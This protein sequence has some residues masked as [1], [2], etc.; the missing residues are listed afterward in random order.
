M[1]L[2]NRFDPPP[3]PPPL[4]PPLDNA[5]PIGE[6]GHP[7]LTPGGSLGEGL[8]GYSGSSFYSTPA[9]TPVTPALN[10]MTPVKAV[11]YVS[12]IKR[13]A[14]VIGITLG[15]AAGAFVGLGIAN[16]IGNWQPP[17]V[18]AGGGCIP[19]PP[20][21]SA[22][23]PTSAPVVANYWLH[24]SCG[25]SYKMWDN[26]YQCQQ[27]I[28]YGYGVYPAYSSPMTLADCQAIVRRGYGMTAWDGT[29]GNWCAPTP[30]AT[31]RPTAGSW[32]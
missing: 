1:A 20:A 24:F 22:P 3:A 28:G 21:P 8:G 12:P 31:K 5:I 7:T 27:T 11:K 2:V 15:C 26:A 29:L 16:A 32:W 25:V 4:P 19:L 6:G 17:A 23:A 14:Q 9:P 18:C 13:I 10:P 30:A